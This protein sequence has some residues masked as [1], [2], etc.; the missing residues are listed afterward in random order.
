[1][2]SC[3]IDIKDEFVPGSGWADIPELNGTLVLSVS[4]SRPGGIAPLSVFFDGT[5]SE[6]DFINA[7]FFWDFDDPSGSHNTAKGFVAAHVFET[8]GT[9]N[10]SVNVTDIGGN[11]STQNI[12][13]EVTAFS[14][15]A[16]YVA[17]GGDDNGPGSEDRPF[18]TVEKGLSMLGPNVQVLF[19]RGD[20]FDVGNYVFEDISGPAIIGAY[21]SGAIPVLHNAQENWGIIAFR[22]VSNDIRIM[23]IMVTGTTLDRTQ[24]TAQAAFTMSD[25]TSNILLLRTEV[26]YVARNAVFLYG[27]NNS[28]FDGYFHDFACYAAYAVG[29]G[30][31]FVGNTSRR[32]TGNEHFYRTQGGSGQFVAFNDFDEI[33]DAKSSIQIRGF[34]NNAVVLSN[35]IRK[36]MG[37]HP[38]NK[39]SEEYVYNCLAEDNVAESGLGITAKNVAVRNNLLLYGITLDSHPLT[40]ISDNVNIFNNTIYGDMTVMV[41]GRGTDVQVKNN[42]YSTITAFKYAAA[43]S[44]PDIDPAEALIDYNGYYA[45]DKESGE[46]LWFN[47]NDV[48]YRSIT[49]WQQTGQDAHSFIADPQFISTDFYSADFL[50]PQA[51]SPLEDAGEHVPVFSDIEGN[52]RDWN[53]PISIGA[54]E[55]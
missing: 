35:R 54:F 49:D 28:V 13:I 22:G 47:F 21:G 53:S 12:S 14:G 18:G 23:D 55:L 11:Q 19:N 43:I 9:Y 10:V 17:A 32:Q 45:P 6:G 30:L 20:A 42:C 34:A 33:T 8:P 38:Q 50:R 41:S 26:E 46:P 1:M 36:G 3:K 29:D 37:F 39:E 31:A 15:T 5:G 16:Y 44:M 51:G 40:G 2:L 24:E 4:A 52:P 25:E 27:T 48:L 7:N